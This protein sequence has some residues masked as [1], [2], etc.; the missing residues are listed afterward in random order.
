MTYTASTKAQRLG[1]IPPTNPALAF[2]S[3]SREAGSPNN[4]RVTIVDDRAWRGE[5]QEQFATNGRTQPSFPCPPPGQDVV[6]AQGTYAIP[7]AAHP[8]ICADEKQEPGD[9]AV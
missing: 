9:S 3:D 7:L 1:L 8:S 4:R 6:G 2:P 5:S